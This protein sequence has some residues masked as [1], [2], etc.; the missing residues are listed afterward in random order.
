[1][2]SITIANKHEYHA[3]LFGSVVLLITLA[4]FWP[5]F[6]NA[7]ADQG[8]DL[9]HM[10]HGVSATAWIVLFLVQSWFTGYAKRR[11]HQWLGW[12]SVAV[13]AVL[14]P[15]S[16]AM[17]HL[18]FAQALSPLFLTLGFID[19]T[20]VPLFLGLYI[21][22]LVYRRRPQVHWRLMA[23]TLVVGVI[24]AAARFFHNSMPHSFH[25]LGK[26]L[27]PSYLLVY[28]LLLLTILIDWRKGRLLWP[29]PFT[30]IYYAV[31]Q[32]TM[33]VG[34]HSTWFFH[35]AKDLALL[36]AG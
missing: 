23:C 11:L 31:I 3:L 25:S 15:S 8:N 9:L 30:L 27:L 14:I 26:A 12:S 6:F 13:A 33:A 7:P 2:P 20:T 35:I 29:F 24:P 4:G 16:F 18:M 1:M 10:L 32:L 36:H 5:T 22:A 17:V 21:A 19:L 34:G 28:A